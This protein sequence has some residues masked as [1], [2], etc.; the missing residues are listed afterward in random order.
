M[1]SPSPGFSLLE[2]LIGGAILLLTLAALFEG[3]I[4]TRHLE[5]YTLSN[6]RQ[7]ITRGEWSPANYL[8]ATCSHASATSDLE[9][10]TC[11]S[12]GS[13]ESAEFLTKH[14]IGK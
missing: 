4:R 14:L 10:V 6:F 3:L 8:R 13:R 1:R 9:I 7:T 11:T 5:K 12:Q 2:C